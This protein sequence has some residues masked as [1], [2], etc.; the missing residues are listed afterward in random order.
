[1][2]RN[3]ITVDCKFRINFVNKLLWAYAFQNWL[4]G[5]RTWYKHP[6]TIHLPSSI[7]HCFK[8]KCKM[9]AEVIFLRMTTPYFLFPFP[10]LLPILY[11]SKS[12]KRRFELTKSA[13]NAKD[14][15]FG[16]HSDS[17]T[18]WTRWLFI[19]KPCSSSILI[20][21]SDMKGENQ[22]SGVKNK[23]RPKDTIQRCLFAGWCLWNH[24]PSKYAPAM[25]NSIDYMKITKYLFVIF[26]LSFKSPFSNSLISPI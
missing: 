1:M 26:C 10:E 6:T 17:S 12:E 21:R 2:F 25:L 22:T 20:D 11:K 3:S 18:G 23:M 4:W 13:Y 19:S 24:H 9:L 7:M 15:L 16:S 14:P 5:K 8:Q